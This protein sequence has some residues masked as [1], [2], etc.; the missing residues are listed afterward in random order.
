MHIPYIGKFLRYKIFEVWSFLKFFANKFLRMAFKER[1]GHVHEFKFS[2]LLEKSVKTY[3]SEHSS[4]HS[5]VNS[6]DIYLS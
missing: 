6:L 2:R 1:S 3:E 5:H 4:R